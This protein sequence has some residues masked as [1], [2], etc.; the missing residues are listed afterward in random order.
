ML[1]SV[2]KG[3]LHLKKHSSSEDCVTEHQ[4]SDI[5]RFAHFITYF[6]LFICSDFLFI[7]SYLK[8]FK[9]YFMELLCLFVVE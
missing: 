9:L 8:L 1:L 3:F 5:Q 2:N 7:M 4:T 6:F